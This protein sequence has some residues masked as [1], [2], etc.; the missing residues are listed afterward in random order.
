MRHE[1]F[2][3]S[4]GP[5]SQT[6]DIYQ[7]CSTRALRKKKKYCDT[8]ITIAGGVRLARIRSIYQEGLNHEAFNSHQCFLSNTSLLR[9]GG[10]VFQQQSRSSVY[11]SRNAI[12][13]VVVR[14]SAEGGYVTFA[15]FTPI[16][17]TIEQH[18]C[19][20][21]FTVW[22]RRRMDLFWGPDHSNVRTCVIRKESN[23]SSVLSI[24]QFP[25]LLR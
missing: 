3:I 11:S 9:I 13:L 23:C 5:L 19:L 7:S 8:L 1:V 14:V 24:L 2:D 18:K 16:I 10:V 21:V 17:S 4:P 12:L 20:C 25:L 15:H 22:K 6:Q